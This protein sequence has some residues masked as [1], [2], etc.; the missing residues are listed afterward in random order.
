V[1]NFIG[2]LKGSLNVD[3]ILDEKENQKYFKVRPRKGEKYKLPIYT[4]N[5]DINGVVKV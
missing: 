3:I 2:G 5:D 4:G 1:A